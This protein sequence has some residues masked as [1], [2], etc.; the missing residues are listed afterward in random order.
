MFNKFIKWIC[1]KKIYISDTDKFLIFLD[2]KY[3]KLSS[4]QKEEINKYKD[5]FNSKNYLK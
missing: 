5:I 4:S 1:K 2:K 3:P